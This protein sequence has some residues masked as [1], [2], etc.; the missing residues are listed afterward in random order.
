MDLAL[1]IIA[2]LGALLFLLSYLGYVF[3]GFKH[4]I[5]TGIIAIM[6]ILNIVTVPSQWHK[7]RNKI[8]MGFIGLAMAVAAWLMGADK[9][10]QKL[11]KQ[12]TL[13]NN[14]NEQIILSS[15]ADTNSNNGST[16]APLANQNVY[17]ESKLQSLPQQALY[18]MHFEIVPLEKIST[19][20]NRIVQI[21]MKDGNL[22]EGRVRQTTAGS[23]ILDGTAA[24]N[25]LPL[26]NIKELKLMVKKSK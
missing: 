14:S 5:V 20:A 11:I 4:H 1:I 23:V 18:K 25:E 7:S 24:D 17:D 10:Y 12:R 2:G 6:P 26:A 21:K 22:I 9:S 3:T 15:Q 13:A 8:I 19:L 16:I